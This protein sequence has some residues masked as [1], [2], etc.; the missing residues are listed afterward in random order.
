M[1]KKQFIQHIIIR[2]LPEIGKLSATIQYAEQLW[3]SMS[4]YGYGAD[5]T[6][7]PREN[8]DYYKA[9]SSTQ[10][11]A[12]DKFW[13]AFRHK[14]D[15][16]GAA[17]RWGQLGELSEAAY[18]TIIEAAKKEAAKPLSNGQVR[19]MAQGWL[20]ERRYEDFI[21]DLPSAK[22]QQNLTLINLEHELLSLKKLYNLSPNEAIGSQI[23][24]IAAKIKALSGEK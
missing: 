3:E 18:N 24:A 15:R 16:N 12:F 20:H 9:L 14:V 17:M 8:Q 13:S 23:K 2:A 4:Y 21:Q 19:K 1:T 6:P 22:K 5:K 7:A 11:V 10:R